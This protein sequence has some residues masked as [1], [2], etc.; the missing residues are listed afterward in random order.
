MVWGCTNIQS[1]ERHV[2]HQIS[3]GQHMCHFRTT[4]QP[5]QANENDQSDPQFRRLG[6]I[7]WLRSMRAGHVE[8]WNLCWHLSLPSYV[9]LQ[10]Q[11]Q[12][13]SIEIPSAST[14]ILVWWNWCLRIE[15][16]WKFGASFTILYPGGQGCAYTTSPSLV[17]SVHRTHCRIS[18]L[19]ISDTKCLI[20]LSAVRARF[21]WWVFILP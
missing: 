3:V 6:H 20:T 2:E 1:P 13:M 5:A 7:P 4:A 12:T 16:T 15:L 9:V 14:K 10:V 17:V 11:W 19:V 8:H 18:D 21:E